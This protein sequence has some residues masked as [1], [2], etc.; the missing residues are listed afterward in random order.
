MPFVNVIKGEQLLNA[1][2]NVRTPIIRIPLWMIIGWHTVKAPAWLVKTLVRYWY[3]TGPAASGPGCIC[4]TAGSA[5]PC[6]SPRAGGG[7]GL[8]V[9]QGS[10]LR[11]GWWPILAR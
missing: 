2:F 9:H 6:W 7:R 8:V 5:R 11:F 3:V 1:T 10:Y 4:G